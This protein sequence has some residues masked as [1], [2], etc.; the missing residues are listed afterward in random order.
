[1]TNAKN[2][3]IWGNKFLGFG[4]AAMEVS[5]GDRKTIEHSG[6]RIE[7]NEIGFTSHTLRTYTPGLRLYG[8]GTKVVYNHFHDI[9]SS[10]IRLEGNDFLVSMNLVERVVTESGDQ[11]GIDI[12]NNPSYYGNIYSYNIWRKVGVHGHGQ[13]GIRF[14]DRI[15]GQIVYGNRFQDASDGTYFGGVQINGGQRNIIDNNV[16]TDCGIGISIGRH[17]K[18]R[19]LE[20]FKSESSIFMLEK[21]VN[22]YAPPYTVKY[23]GIET[24]RDVYEQTNRV[25]RNVFV[26]GGTFTKVSANSN[27]D[28]HRNWR[29]KTLPDLDVLAK[30]TAFSPLPPESDIGT[31]F[32]FGSQGDRHT[33]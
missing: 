16:F 2:V 19:W 31:Y 6:I 18:E 10:A 12:Y 28:A 22:I 23:P 30:E 25:T 13:A 17:S 7:N 26:G 3:M 20:S 8:C 33:P 5:G 11:G 4:R 21:A 15:S 27:L 14:D 24:L 9:L 29:F 1:M 32:T